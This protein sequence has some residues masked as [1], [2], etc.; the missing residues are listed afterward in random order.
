MSI[1]IDDIKALSNKTVIDTSN[2]RYKLTKDLE[3]IIHSPEF[4]ILGFLNDYMYCSDGLYLSKCTIDGEEIAQLKVEIEHATFCNKSKLFYGFGGK[5]L[6]QIDESL[7]IIWSKEFETDI[8]SIT[9]DPEGTVYVLFKDT[10]VLRKILVDKSEVFY[11][12]GSDS[13]VSTVRLQCMT[14]SK[15]YG[16]LYIV[17]TNFDKGSFIDKYNTRTG[18]IVESVCIKNITGS[19]NVS[20]PD[21]NYSDIFIKDDYV[22][23]YCNSHIFKTNI[24]AG[25][26]YWRFY[27]T[28]NLI[29]LNIG[30]IEYSDNP[31]TEYLYYYSGKNRLPVYDFGKISTNGKMIWSLRT[32]NTD[33]S[34]TDFKMCTYK[35]RIYTIDKDFVDSL[36]EYILSLNDNQ[37]LFKTQ[38]GN[39]IKVYKYNNEE[40]YDPNNYYEYRLVGDKIK[41]GIDKI[42]DYPL[43]HD[44]G[45]VITDDNFAI[46]VETENDDYTN[47]E[48]YEYFYLLASNYTID[49]SD[50]S[51]LKDKTGKS[52]FTKLANVLKTKEPYNPQP[53]EEYI[54]DNKGNKVDTIDNSDL[55][56]SR[57]LY[58]VDKFLLADKHKF[59][60][61]IVTKVLG[62]IIITKKKGHRLIKK[63]RSVYRY[64]LSRFDDINIVQ[65]W[66]EENGVTE[67]SL[68]KYVD[69]LRHH[70]LG[71]INDI[72]ISGVPT[73][74]DIQ[75][76]QTFRYTFEGNEYPIREWGTLIFSCMNLPFTKHKC[77][78]KPYI[79]GLINMIEEKELRPVIFFINGKAIPWSKCTIIRD[80]SYNYLMISDINIEDTTRLDCIIIPN[81]VKYGEDNKVLP[82]EDRITNFL[83]DAEGKVTRDIDKVTI[84][85]EIVD[86]NIVGEHKL[87][88]DTNYIEVP[89]NYT[90]V[91]SEQNIII[92]ENGMLNPNGKYFLN[93]HG[94]D[95]FTYKDGEDN[96]NVEY[97]TFYWIKANDY[98]GSL[99][100]LPNWPVVTDYCID[101]A[102]GK[103]HHKEIDNFNTPFEFKMYREKTYAENVSQAVEYI[104]NYNMSLLIDYYKEDVNVKS[105]TYTGAQLIERVPKDG[106]WLVVPRARK[107]G[108]DDY[109][110]VFKNRTL[111]EYYEQIERDARTFR[112]PI[113]NHV[114]R[115]DIIE[116]IHFTK[117]DNSYYTLT[118]NDEM[119][120]LPEKLRYDNFLL[121]A[122]VPIDYP[123]YLDF[124]VEN[125]RQYQVFFDYKN[126]FD[127]NRKYIG[128]NIKLNSPYY[129]NKT[130]NLCSKR[131]FQYMYYNIYIDKNY[132]DLAPQFRFCQSAFHYMIF[133]NGIRVEESKWSLTTPDM[134]HKYIRIGFAETLHEGDRL[135]IFYLPYKCT[136]FSATRDM[137][138]IDY[139]IGGCSISVDL[140]SMHSS[141]PLDKDLYM[142]FVNNNKI[143]YGY[144]DN[145]SSDNMYIDIDRMVNSE[146]GTSH[147]DLDITRIRGRI[148]SELFNPYHC[149]ITL[150][151]FYDEE[152]LLN[153]II[154]YSDLWSSS[155]NKLS[156]SDYAK[157]L[158]YK[159]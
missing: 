154:S 61:N 156:S 68:P 86:P 33:N 28:Y 151:R 132:I 9:M 117:V 89:N 94:R 152:E 50:I 157:L 95:I 3:R 114:D 101:D 64:V 38:N 36:K 66:L 55:V 25:I 52:L 84:R 112:I 134:D 62:D 72:Q 158:V 67:T 121:F 21:Y 145:I 63:I 23:I 150:I 99:Y 96:S 26:E 56:R 97:K 123:K 16:W 79:D 7:N 15:G 34:Y 124:D 73:V 4:K 119:D 130:L 35:K 53:T 32:V 19:A 76:T 24:K 147:T 77:I 39:L 81:N 148:I 113:F 71:M 59:S 133:K 43:L 142:V 83:F 105:Y 125:S 122:N 22:Y 48:N 153:K 88:T 6:Y 141:V 137:I 12:N 60:N 2:E 136:L 80:W 37:L 91:A 98:Y 139:D 30:H 65:K 116:I 41:D 11:I 149:K 159:K 58:S 100:K 92:F 69:E 14:L 138:N 46:L 44:D 135:D 31:L 75:P 27:S 82:E 115:N 10:C 108:Y 143:N 128:T 49:L 102:L 87:Y 8:T 155:I 131:Q 103:T 51:I 57:L 40:I 29:G 5:I 47:P 126:N 129:E 110:M 118:V 127:E 111:Y 18:E 107:T 144:I 54:V 13:P 146:L 120:Y 45:N 104:M 90:Q 42:V 70:T 85:V 20:D 78:H 106:G 140:S 74:Y 109:V 93:N 1:A 17:R